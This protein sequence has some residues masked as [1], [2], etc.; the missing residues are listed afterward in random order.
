MIIKIKPEETDK[1]MKRMLESNTVFEFISKMKEYEEI[2]EEVEDYLDNFNYFVKY[3]TYKKGD[4]NVFELEIKSEHDINS[5]VANR[6]SHKD[7]DTIFFIYHKKKDNYVY[8]SLRMQKGAVNLG[9]IAKE[10]SVFPQTNGGG[11]IPAAGARVPKDHFKEFR[12]LFYDT[13]A[14]VEVQ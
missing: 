11:H 5:I 9:K 6:I 4:M 3:G 1:I 13:L 2:E 12:E 14:K 10:C 8:I 7:P